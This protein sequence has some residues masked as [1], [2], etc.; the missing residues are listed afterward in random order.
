MNFRDI[1]QAVKL[2]FTD[3]EEVPVRHMRATLNQKSAFS[4]IQVKNDFEERIKLQDFVINALLGSRELTPEVHAGIIALGPGH[5]DDRERR[6]NILEVRVELAGLR[7]MEP[8]PKI[9]ARIA[10]A[11]ERLAKLLEASAEES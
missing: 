1:K 5:A 6:I 9:N 2:M 4:M 3:R 11:E 10:K 8:T 7:E